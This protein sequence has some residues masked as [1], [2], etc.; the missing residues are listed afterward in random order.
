MTVRPDPA[1]LDGEACDD[2]GIGRARTGRIAA[3]VLPLVPG[4]A[5]TVTIAVAATILRG[6]P[7]MSIF[8]A[9]ILAAIIGMAIRNGFGI[10][11]RLRAGIGFSMRLP[12]RTAIVLLGLQLTL[13]QLASIGSEA[14]IV[15]TLSL[16][17]TFAFVIA[18]GRAVRVD[19][20]LT[21]LLA[22]GISICGAAAIVAGSSVVRAKDADVFYALGCITLF[23]T[24]VM[25]VYPPLAAASGLAPATFGIW[26]GASIHEVAQ[27]VG[28]SFQYGQVAGEVGTIAKLTRVLML[29]PV[30]LLLPFLMP[31]RNA[32]S[33]AAAKIPVPWFVF[34]FVAMVGL[35]SLVHLSVQITAIAGQ[36]TTFL[37]AIAL[38]AM[39]LETDLRLLNSRGFRPLFLAGL[40][41]AFISVF[42]FLLIRLLMS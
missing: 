37:L 9:M 34:G 21:Y 20:G 35:S 14:F 28:A 38:A 10:N 19:Y 27:V 13:A 36:V 6:L 8:S 31:R 22:I 40:G 33:A 1:E 29:A 30:V 25:F 5:L 12:L 16:I 23:G 2:S 15:V 24:I 3:T 32:G 11:E 4:L 17:T 18:A 7:G 41:T 39:G 26:A 42:S